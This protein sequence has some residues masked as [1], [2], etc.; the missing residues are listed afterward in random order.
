MM[1]VYGPWHESMR[2]L[3]VPLSPP[4][5]AATKSDTMKKLNREEQPQD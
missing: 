3:L 2:E 1:Q 5:Q 4:E